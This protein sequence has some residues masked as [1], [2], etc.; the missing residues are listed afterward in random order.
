LFF[1]DVKSF[2]FHLDKL[3]EHIQDI[4]S[5]YKMFIESMLFLFE[6]EPVPSYKYVYE[7]QQT[8]YAQSKRQKSITYSADKP[9]KLSK[10]QK[11]ILEL[12]SKSYKNAEIVEMTGLSINTIRTHTKIIYQKLGVGTAMDA[13][14]RARELELI[15]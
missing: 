10:Q 6:G 12:L 15:D 2:F 3:Y 11:Y 5:V 8:A 13:I 7:L 9:I 1:S 4:V 14:L